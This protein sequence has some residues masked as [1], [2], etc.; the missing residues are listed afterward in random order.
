[1][2]EAAAKANPADKTS[3]IIPPGPR[4]GTSVL[5]VKGLSKSY[6]DQKLIDNLSFRLD[7]GAIIGAF[8]SCFHLLGVE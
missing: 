3:L 8:E 5:E 7:R 6:G 2:A 1:M 4:L